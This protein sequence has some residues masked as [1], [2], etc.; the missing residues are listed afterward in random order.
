MGIKVQ[1]VGGRSYTEFRTAN[2]PIG[3][4]RGMTRE[5]SD[6]DGLVVKKLVD[7]GSTMWMIV[8]DEPTQTD[9]MKSAIEP[10]VEEPGEEPE[11]DYNKLSRAKLMALCKER[12]IAVKNTS[13]KA[14]LIE[15]L[16]A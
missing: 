4:A 12:G 3:F 15:L 2:G 5:L 16:S 9:A 10:T 13:K 8:G 6:V 7:D 14:E 11:I 1:Y